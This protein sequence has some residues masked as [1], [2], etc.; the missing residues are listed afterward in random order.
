M[1]Q[2]FL[3]ECD[4][5][6]L[7]IWGRGALDFQGHKVFW[8]CYEAAPASASRCIVDP[9]EAVRLDSSAP[10]ML[11]LLRDR[12]GGGEQVQL[13]NATGSVLRALKVAN[14]QALFDK[15]GLE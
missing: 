8:R 5:E 7:I 1:E 12:A 2:R 10:G 13:R 3:T 14:F 15:P 4:E 6:P 11:L 9:Q